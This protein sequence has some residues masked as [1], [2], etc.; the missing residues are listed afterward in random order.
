MPE[1]SG[2]ALRV[3]LED[4]SYLMHPVSAG[5]LELVKSRLL[6]AWGEQGPPADV[7]WTLEEV[8]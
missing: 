6:L 3:S 5:S 4:G 1:R 7:V 2:T 8:G